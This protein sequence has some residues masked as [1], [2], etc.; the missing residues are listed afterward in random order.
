MGWTKKD[1][2]L[3]AGK[4][5]QISSESQTDQSEQ[6]STESKTGR[7]I[8]KYSEGKDSKLTNADFKSIVKDRS[9]K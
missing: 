5:L 3:Q 2:N 9:G 4:R 7:K 1:N 6:I 8:T